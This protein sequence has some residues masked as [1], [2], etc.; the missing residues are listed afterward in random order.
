MYQAFA[1]GAR[2]RLLL[3]PSVVSF[4]LRRAF[5]TE[6]LSVLIF[7]KT[8]VHELVVEVQRGQ[9]APASFTEKGLRGLRHSF[10]RA[11]EA[12]GFGE[13][14]AFPHGVPLLLLVILF[15]QSLVARHAQA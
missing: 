10:C 15:L 3:L 8:R 11:R 12:D 5:G 9:N 13:G 1:R 14:F 7:E 2:A 6:Q 4:T